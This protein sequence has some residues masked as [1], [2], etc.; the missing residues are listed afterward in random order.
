MNIIKKI[1]HKILTN[2]EHTYINLTIIY[3]YD[4]IIYSMSTKHK[5]RRSNS[6]NIEQHKQNAN[7]NKNE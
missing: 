4:N 1:K 5:H 3:I 2:I 6:T 7:N